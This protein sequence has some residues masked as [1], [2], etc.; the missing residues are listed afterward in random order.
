MDRSLHLGLGLLGLKEF[1]ELTLAV[2]QKKLSDVSPVA[3]SI[4]FDKVDMNAIKVVR[5]RMV[6]KPVRSRARHSTC[7]V[8]ARSEPPW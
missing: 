4:E 6:E 7:E 3:S 8:R 5:R 2:R 1:G